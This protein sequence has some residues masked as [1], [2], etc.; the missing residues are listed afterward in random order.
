MLPPWKLS[1]SSHNMSDHCCSHLHIYVSHGVIDHSTYVI[2]LDQESAN[3]KQNT[4]WS[5]VDGALFGDEDSS[6]RRVT[7]ISIV[8]FSID[9]IK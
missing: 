1:N 8:P 9:L 3:E 5:F 4:L 7:I 2:E 6:K